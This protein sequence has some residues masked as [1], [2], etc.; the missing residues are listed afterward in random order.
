MSCI[1]KKF[2]NDSIVNCNEPNCSDEHLGCAT[3]MLSSSTVEEEPTTMENLPYL[4]MTA[5]ISLVLTMLAFGALIWIVYKIRS[6]C[7]PAVMSSA[8]IT[9]EHPE[10]RR[11]HRNRNEEAPHEL[12]EHVP[13]APPVDK[14]DQPP[15]YDALFPEPH[16]KPEALNT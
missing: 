16:A 10:R 11:R 12:Q 1:S 15:P 13:S 14:D 6:C 5:I 4:L 2:A 7:C 9:N 8:R 3:S